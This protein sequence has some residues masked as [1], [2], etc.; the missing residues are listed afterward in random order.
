MTEDAGQV[1]GV[2]VEKTSLGGRVYRF[3]IEL[4]KSK[5]NVDATEIGRVEIPM[6]TSCDIAS[7]GSAMVILSYFGIYVIEREKLAD[8]SWEAWEQSLKRP[9]KGYRVPTFAQVEAICFGQSNQQIWL[10]HEKVTDN[11]LD[12]KAQVASVRSL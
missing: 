9:L 8:G 7:D 12:S 11:A 6:A 4:G 3:P 10:T 5:V 1:T 2:L